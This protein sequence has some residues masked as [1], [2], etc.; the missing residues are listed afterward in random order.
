MANVTMRDLGRMLGV[1]AVT[2]SKALSG[3]SGV[4]ED[5][6]QRILRLA[7]ET[8][9]VNPK[10]APAPRGQDV[11]VLVPEH[12]FSNDT[13]YAMFYKR[14]VEALAE[15]GRFALLEL[16]TRDM[17]DSM[18][19]PNLVRSRRV[20]ALLLL[21]Q[22]DEA[23]ARMLTELN[24]PAV[25]LDFYWPGLTMDAVVSDGLCGAAAMTRTLIDAGHREIG[26][27]G[28][29]KA[30]SSIMERYL[31]FH[32]EMLRQG[33]TVRPEWVL[34]DRENAGAIQLP[35]LPETLPTAFVCNCDIS[36]RALIGQLRL[37][38]L[39]VP[40]DVSVVGFDDFNNVPDSLPLTTWHVDTAA[41]CRI[42]VSRIVQRLE[43]VSE[44]PCRTVV[45]G[46]VV[47]RDSVSPVNPQ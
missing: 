39:R 33:L 26:F 47:S 25:A 24:V 40:E 12:F 29:A 15:S 5:M 45:P 35:A 20:D 1:S 21:G 28:N 11:G 41:M 23:Y 32:G 19:L 10:A 9:Y 31:G 7:E 2:I 30:T 4:S 43:G 44:T 22:P 6:R 36:A 3:K 38:G 46:Q 37:A 13:F 16:I 18:T 42:A 34:P 17:Q 8:G 27:L 14:L